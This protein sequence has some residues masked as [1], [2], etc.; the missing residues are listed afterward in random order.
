MF[1]NR[2]I[3]N[4]GWVAATTPTTPPWVSV[5]RQWIQSMATSGSCTTSRR[6]SQQANNLAKS[7]PEKLR[8]LQRLF[9]I[10]AAKYN[11]LPL[12]NTRWNGSTSATGR[13]TSV[14]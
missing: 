14:A 12:D 9:Y 6:T 1:A 2:A 7:N 13:A 10:E 11:V 3:Y 8:E 5:A 4:D